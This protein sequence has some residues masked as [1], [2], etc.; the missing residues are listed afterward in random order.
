MDYRSSVDE[1]HDSEVSSTLNSTGETNRRHSPRQHRHKPQQQQQQKKSLWS[2]L[3]G[4]GD[5]SSE[6]EEDE[7]DSIQDTD[8][9]VN[10]VKLL[11]RHL[12]RVKLEAE[13]RAHQLKLQ[14]RK[15]EAD[16]Q[17][18][19]VVLRE[20]LE[21]AAQLEQQVKTLEVQN[22]RKWQIES[23]DH[24]IAQVETLKQERA[25]LRAENEKMAESLKRLESAI[26]GSSED[27]DEAKSEGDDASRTNMLTKDFTRALKDLGEVRNERD[28]LKK[29]LDE[30]NQRAATAEAEAKAL[31]KKLDFELE[32]KWERTHGSALDEGRPSSGSLLESIAEV[33]A[34]RLT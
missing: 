6:G 13:E 11:G 7:A 20:T 26:I 24:W 12:A 27:A 18:Q 14:I 30:A 1:D 17:E 23:R 19:Q 9:D 21:R 8:E 15:L 34:P 31:K 4:G 10:G 16:K 29:A 28:A 32:L 22:T 25:R 2:Q 5:S 33:V 3:L